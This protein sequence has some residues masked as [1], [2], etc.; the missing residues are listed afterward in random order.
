MKKIILTISIIFLL[1]SVLYTNTLATEIIIGNT[2]SSN[3]TANNTSN[4]TNSNSNSNIVTNTNKTNTT[5][6][7]NTTNKTNSSYK[8]TNLPDTGSEDFV[9]GFVILA[10]LA[11]AV[12][13]YI[14]IKTYNI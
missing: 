3:T 6:K 12:Y 5:N 7:I 1:L 2:P 9:Y 4:N 8:N 10:G 13:A 11:S 14:K